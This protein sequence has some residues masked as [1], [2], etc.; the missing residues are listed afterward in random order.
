MSKVHFVF[1]ELSLCI[2]FFQ[3]FIAMAVTLFLLVI[4]AILAIAFH[5][6]V[7]LLFIFQNNFFNIS[8]NF[9]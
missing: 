1:P 3:F 8:M 9:W 2:S 4:A 6:Q 5:A 7:S